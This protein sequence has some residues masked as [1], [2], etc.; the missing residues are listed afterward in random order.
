MEKLSEQ[1][2]V[3]NRKD[4]VNEVELKETYKREE[5]IRKYID[6]IEI[7]PLDENVRVK[8]FDEYVYH[9]NGISD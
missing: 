8:N 6:M 3:L 4:F 2:N 1:T 7:K 5:S 9:K